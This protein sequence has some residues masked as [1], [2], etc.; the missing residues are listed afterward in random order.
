MGRHSSGERR[1]RLESSGEQHPGTVEDL[2][3][4]V[5]TRSLLLASLGAIILI[6]A[7]YFGV[8]F[9]VGRGRDWL[10]LL[11]IPAGLAGVTVGA[12]LDRAH[13]ARSTPATREQAGDSESTA[14]ESPASESP[15]SPEDAP[16]DPPGDQ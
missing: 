8:L 7:G 2:R 5:G 13:K 16:E 14:S 11:I 6:F 10:L 4:L 9:A 3:L 1:S 12:L 15:A